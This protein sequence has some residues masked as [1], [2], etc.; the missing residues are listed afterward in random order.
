MIEI[1]VLPMIFTL[2]FLK[3]VNFGEL[4]A[5]IQRKKSR[6]LKETGNIF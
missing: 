1:S 4:N 6:I 5:L 3:E 2:L